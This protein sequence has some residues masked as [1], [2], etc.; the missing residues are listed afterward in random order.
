MTGTSR[1][2][3]GPGSAWVGL[4]DT[5][6]TCKAYAHLLVLFLC[7]QMLSPLIPLLHG[8]LTCSQFVK[9]TF[10]ILQIS[11]SLVL[12]VPAGVKYL[13]DLWRAC[14][15][16]VWDTVLTPPWL[17]DPLALAHLVC[18]GSVLCPLLPL[19]KLCSSLR[20]PHSPLMNSICLE[21]KKTLATL[22]SP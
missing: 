13:Q 16:T 2:P 15:D 1:P 3:R 8:P 7:P 10:M 5:T 4:E 19:L 17:T 18:K 22:P 11:F 21:S 20:D 9:V 6:H 12:L 14:G